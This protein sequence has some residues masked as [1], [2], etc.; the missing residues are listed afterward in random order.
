M[1]T[2][3]EAA[4]LYLDVM[5][6]DPHNDKQLHYRIK[7]QSEIEKAGHSDAVGQGDVEME[8]WRSKVR[9][10]RTGK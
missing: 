1:D 9:K 4:Q 3:L 6:T 10:W 7:L 2:L 8:K 5:G